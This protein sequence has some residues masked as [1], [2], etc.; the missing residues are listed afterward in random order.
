MEINQAGERGMRSRLH[1][2]HGADTITECRKLI[3]SGQDLRF[4]HD[5]RSRPCKHARR[6]LARIAEPFARFSGNYC[7]VELMSARMLTDD[8]ADEIKVRVNNAG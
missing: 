6:A 5:E 3:S 8:R 1:A 7:I 2:N 4:I